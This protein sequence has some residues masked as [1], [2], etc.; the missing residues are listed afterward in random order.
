MQHSLSQ[1]AWEWIK[2][3]PEFTSKQLA[4]HMEVSLRSAQMVIAYLQ[5]KKA[6]QTLHSSLNPV[7]YAAVDGACPVFPGKA[8]FHPRLKSARQTM[9]QAMRF[10]HRFT[11]CEV[12]ATAETSRANVMKFLSDLTKAGYVK[13][14]TPQ[15]RKAS[16]QQ[17]R[18]H[19]V[20]YLLV[21][22]TGRL[23]PIVRPGEVYD[24]NLKT[25]TPIKTGGLDAVA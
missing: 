21:K 7:I 24:Q 3:Q 14:I 10:L 9:W 16:M 12:E 11:V 19:K 15:R 18:G 23:Y 22:N 4:A 6:I 5:E 25:T 13:I 1:R 17:R 8:R 2:Q 20:Q